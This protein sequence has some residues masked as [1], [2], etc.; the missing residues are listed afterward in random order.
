MKICFTLD[1]VIR[2][3]T[4]QI[5]KIYKKY[6]DKDIDLD[7]LDF[8]NF[9]DYWKIFGF[10]DEKEY[11]NFL[12]QEY[13]FEIFAEASVTDKMVDKNLNMWHLHANDDKDINETIELCL[14]NPLEFNNSIGFTYF[15]LS[16]IATRIREVYLPTDSLSI[17]DKCD[18]L[19][20]ANPKLLRNKPV[21]KIAI[22]IE[23]PY[24]ENIESDFKYE[25]LKDFLSD[26]EIIKKIINKRATDNE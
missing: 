17:W 20:T 16:R 4:M 7:S 15:F 3:K 13:A 14:A 21:N 2:A 26:K 5:G 25:S 11:I 9:D 19:V 10:K 18:V 24:N 23:M 1:D 8:S 12:Y 6:I 22:K